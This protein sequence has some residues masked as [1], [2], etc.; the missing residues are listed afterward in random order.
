MR[1]LSSDVVGYVSKFRRS[2][3]PE[4]NGT[5]NAE[6]RIP[7]SVPFR[8]VGDVSGPAD[9]RKWEGVNGENREKRT[10]VP[11][12]ISDIYVNSRQPQYC[13]LDDGFSAPV[14]ATT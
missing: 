4:R 9:V 13:A 12:I 5:R 14:H 3:A 11:E 1:T 2:V 8:F 10:S 7:S 6:F